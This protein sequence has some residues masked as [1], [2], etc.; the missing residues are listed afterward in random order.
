MPAPGYGGYDEATT[1]GSEG[2]SRVRRAA[3]DAAMNPERRSKWKPPE[4][5]GQESAMP[6]REKEYEEYK[7][8]A[9]Q[10]GEPAPFVPPPSIDEERRARSPGLKN[11][12]FDTSTSDFKRPYGSP[13]GAVPMP[14]PPQAPVG[15]VA[16]TNWSPERPPEPPKP[17]AGPESEAAMEAMDKLLSACMKQGGTRNELKKRLIDAVNE[18]DQM[19]R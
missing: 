7:K 16:P 14:E 17:P 19:E 1:F 4:G 18:I 9:P 13:P 10:E 11:N 3:M 12:F 15:V 5:Y 2:M 6:G 8:V